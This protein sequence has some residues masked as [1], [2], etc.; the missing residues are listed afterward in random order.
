VLFFVSVGM[1]FDPSVL[2]QQPMHLLVLVAVIV[3]WKG[4]LTFGLVRALK[5]PPGTALLMGA[6]VGQIG[7]LSFIVAELGVSL[8]IVPREAQTLIVTAALIAITINAP[9]LSGAARLSRTVSE[10]N[11][12]IALHLF[13]LENHV[14]LVGYGRVGA[15][16][17]EA[18]LRAEAPHIIV[19]EQERVVEGLRKRGLFVIRG[20]ATRADVLERARVGKARLLV[21]T[22]PE[23]FRARRIVEVARVANPS[24]TVAVRTHSASEQTF[25][26]ELLDASKAGGRAVYTEREAALSL[27]H[28]SLVALGRSDD[29]ADMLIDSMR[30]TNYTGTHNPS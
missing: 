9:L 7:E 12:P 29:E 19:E 20:D 6:G 28:Y 17:S 10:R 18:L 8:G 24:I 26:E 14:V 27:A 3:L 15:T 5:E 23:T 30:A 11:E 22:A 25:F 16:I 21:V 13:E 2:A 4:S 1:L